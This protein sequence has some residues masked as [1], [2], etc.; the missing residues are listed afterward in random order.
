MSRGH[1]TPSACTR[2]GP[3]CSD[4]SHGMRDV[5]MYRPDK[6]QE[7]VACTIAKGWQQVV[8]GKEVYVPGVLG[9]CFVFAHCHHCNIAPKPMSGKSSPAQIDMQ[10]YKS[11]EVQVPVRKR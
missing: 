9:P 5:L 3:V 8:H 10:Y 6:A 7:C 11:Q 1:Q 2:P 4:P